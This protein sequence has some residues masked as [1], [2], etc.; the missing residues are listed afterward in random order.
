MNDTTRQNEQLIEMTSAIV[1][2]YVENNGVAVSD[3]PKLIEN[4]HGA[5][6]GLA[7]SGSA[8]PKK[9]S[10]VPIK[11]SVRSDQLICLGCG[12]AMKMLKRHIATYH[13]MTPDEYRAYW[14]LPADY[15]MV[16]KEYAKTRSQLAKNIGLGR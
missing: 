10:A 2:A 11:D 1:S 5:L 4:V 7:G 13:D 12:A 15:P 8:K 16:S 9:N 6:K 3:L 14:R